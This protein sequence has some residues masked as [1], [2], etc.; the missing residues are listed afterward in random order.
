[1]TGSIVL[2]GFMG[3]GKTTVGKRLAKLLGRQYCDLDQYI[4]EKAGMTVAEIFAQYGEAGF[5]L[6]ETQAAGELAGKSG[7]VISAGGGTVLYLQNVEAFHAG[8]GVIVFLDVPL[9]ILQERLKDDNQRPLL[10]TGDRNRVIAQLLR[11][12]EA[13]YRAAADLTVDGSKAP[14]AVAKSIAVLVR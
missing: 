3:C 9:E 6:R 7:L 10:Q 1:M 4:E 5:R 11:E 8:G 12:R 2:C 13:K 14:L